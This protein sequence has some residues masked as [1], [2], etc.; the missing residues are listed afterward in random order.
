MKTL[1]DLDHEYLKRIF[2]KPMVSAEENKK[3]SRTDLRVT[4]KLIRSFAPNKFVT[5]LSAIDACLRMFEKRDSC[6]CEQFRLKHQMKAN[7]VERKR[8]KYVSSDCLDL[9]L[10]PRGEEDIINEANFYESIFLKFFNGQ[11]YLLSYKRIY[12][13]GRKSNVEDSWYL[14]ML[15][16]NKKDIFYL[17]SF[18]TTTSADE[19]PQLQEYMLL[20]ETHLNELLRTQILPLV[21][22]DQA[23]VQWRVNYYPFAYFQPQQNDFDSALYILSALYFISLDCPIYF[24]EQLMKTARYNFSHWLMKDSSLP[25]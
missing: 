21:E 25:M 23:H 12:F 17:D 8:S 14:V 11:R 5:N 22:N 1:S 18:H 15:E 19:S 16:T 4:A 9:L 24:T 20:I 6:I 7:Y 3:L 10:H 13:V 2:T